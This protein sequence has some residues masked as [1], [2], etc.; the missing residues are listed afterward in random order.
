MLRAGSCGGM[1]HMELKTLQGL[2]SIMRCGGTPFKNFKAPF[3]WVENQVGGVP[4]R[5]WNIDI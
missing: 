5:A 2:E 1:E 3:W 4:V